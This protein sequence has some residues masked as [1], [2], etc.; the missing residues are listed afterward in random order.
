MGMGTATTVLYAMFAG[1]QE[2]KGE[3]QPSGNFILCYWLPI[4]FFLC[5][6]PAMALTAYINQCQGV[7]A[8]QTTGS[9]D[10]CRQQ[11]P[12]HGIPLHLPHSIPKELQ[13]TA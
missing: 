4:H 12:L 7:E 1:A 10:L 5:H 8:A 13:T 2:G 3:N 6:C 9:P 11:S